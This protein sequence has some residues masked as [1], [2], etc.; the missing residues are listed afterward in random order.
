MSS[1]EVLT[2][3]NS[4]DHPDYAQ[5][6]RRR[7]VPVVG[8][9]TSGPVSRFEHRRR[10]PYAAHLDCMNLNLMASSCCVLRFC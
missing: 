3:T 5:C 6:V 7:R 4:L 10:L 2:F 1:P 9:S 8:F